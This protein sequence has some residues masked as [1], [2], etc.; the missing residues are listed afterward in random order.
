MSNTGNFFKNEGIREVTAAALTANYAVLGA[1]VQHRAHIITVF[2]NSNG[3]VSFTRNPLVD[4]KKQPANSGRVTDYKADDGVEGKGTQY[5]VK[6]S[7]A[8]PA[9]PTGSFWIEVEYV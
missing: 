1:T 4:E 7:G 3:D 9:V 6:W 8:A 5:Y 2:N